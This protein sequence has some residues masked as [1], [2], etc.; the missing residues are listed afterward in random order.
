MNTRILTFVAG[1]LLV[2]CGEKAQ[3][4]K[5]AARGGPRAAL[6]QMGTRVR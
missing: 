1:A 3:E 5:N 6:N 4:M 2:G